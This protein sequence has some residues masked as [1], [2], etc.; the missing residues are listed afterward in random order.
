MPDGMIAAFGAKPA[1]H[2]VGSPALP[3]NSPLHSQLW[4][5][6]D[7][8]SC[9]FTWILVADQL[10]NDTVEEVSSLPQETAGLSLPRFMDRARLVL[11]DLGP[12]LEKVN[13]ILEELHQDIAPIKGPD[14]PDP[15][16]ALWEEMLATEAEFNLTCDRGAHE[17]AEQRMHA[18]NERFMAATPTTAIGIALKLKHL[19]MV[20]SHEKADTAETYE[21]RTVRDLVRQLTGDPNWVSPSYRGAI[22]DGGPAETKPTKIGKPRFKALWSKEEAMA[23]INDHLRL[24]HPTAVGERMASVI[25]SNDA[26]ELIKKPLDEEVSEEML[27]LLEGAAERL[28]V[29]LQFV[30]EALRR[31]VAA[32][33]YRLCREA[34]KAQSA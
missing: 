10:L 30:R 18:A 17:A 3:I 24:D 31:S 14:T 5:K 7:D 16:V 11:H 12:R 25:L 23:A 29:R 32:T 9:H 2:L 15:L 26:A 27:N 21:V 33:G 20:N 1:E 13:Q 22:D 19:A 28:E 4:H 6:I 8:A 34:A